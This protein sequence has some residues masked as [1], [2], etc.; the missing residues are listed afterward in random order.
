LA[1]VLS[2]VRRALKHRG[3]FY[4]SFKSGQGG[5]RD[6]FGRYFNFVTQETL[7]GAYRAAGTW[8]ELNIREASGGGYDGVRVVW[9]RCFAVKG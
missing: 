8:D 4:A 1:G 5:G 7:T 9:L 6:R 3:L 2:Q